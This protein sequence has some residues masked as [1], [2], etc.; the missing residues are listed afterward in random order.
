M[1]PASFMTKIL[2]LIAP[3]ILDQVAKVFKLDKV[4]SYVEKPN[5]AD[6]KIE[7]L[8]IS[9]AAKEVKIEY[10]TELIKEQGEQI[11]TLTEEIKVMKKQL[12]KLK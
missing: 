1:I 8:E 7:I 3:K 11:E 10:Q 5:D 2:S 6:K 9:D 4:L 12:N